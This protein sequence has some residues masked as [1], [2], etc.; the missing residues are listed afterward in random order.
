MSGPVVVVLAAG[1][2]SRF[3]GLEH[4]LAQALGA[5]T[6]LGT[7]LR[8]VLASRLPMIVV[9]TAALADIARR[10]VATRDIVVLPDVGTPGPQPLG[11][12]YSIACGVSAR[13]DASG[14]LILPSDMPMVQPATLQLVARELSHHTV[15]YAQY[16]GQRG[17]PV[18]FSAELYSELVALGGDEGARRLVA[19]YPAH[20]VEVDD[21]G[22][23]IDIDTE[24]DLDG[25]R[26]GKLPASTASLP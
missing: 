23:L 5:S 6:V 1:R 19:R 16:R 4:K 2:G 21:P 9:T 25:L 3:R 22:A 14:W 20:G 17:H 12:G 18:G 13:P 11:M 15:A 24:A 8:Q 7:T 26:S 10:S